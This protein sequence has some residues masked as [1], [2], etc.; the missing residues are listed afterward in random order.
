M[1]IKGVHVENEKSR[2]S[3]EHQGLQI[4]DFVS[5]TCVAGLAA[6]AGRLFI[7]STIFCQVPGIRYQVS[8]IR[9]HVSGIRYQ[10][11]GIRY[12]V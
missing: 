9:Y 8:G 11:A 5:K 10:V 2:R 1:G 3:H 7:I 6:G 4:T 12:Q